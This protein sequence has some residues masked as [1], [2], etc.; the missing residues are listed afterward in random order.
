[1]MEHICSVMLYCLTQIQGSV[2][3]R[4]EERIERLWQKRPTHISI[5]HLK[6]NLYYLILC[7]YVAS[8][9]AGDRI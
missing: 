6:S 1:M 8:S 7:S 9:L 5:R 4:E 3:K 2:E